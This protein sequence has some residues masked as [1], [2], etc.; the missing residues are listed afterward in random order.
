MQHLQ[1]TRGYPDPE[2]IA[3]NEE[4]DH[5]GRGPLLAFE[6]DPNS[7]VRY[8]QGLSVPGYTAFSLDK[9]PGIAPHPF[10]VDQRLKLQ[11]RFRAVRLGLSL[12]VE[13][14]KF[15]PLSERQQKSSL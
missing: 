2:R 9:E 4:S 15:I 6:W 8:P 5:I 7:A 11:A 14:R 10:R 12:I 1:K 13:V 3:T